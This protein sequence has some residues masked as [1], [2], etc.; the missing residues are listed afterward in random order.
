MATR[1]RSRIFEWEGHTS[2]A[3]WCEYEGVE[4]G[5]FGKLFYFLLTIFVGRVKSG[6][7]EGR[8]DGR[9]GIGP[10]VTVEPGPLRALLRQRHLT[11]WSLEVI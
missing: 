10:Q 5:G 1:G 2:S 7:K 11:S 3:K 4:E 6:E 9:E 8:E